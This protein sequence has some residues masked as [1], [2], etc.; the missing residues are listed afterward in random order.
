MKYVVTLH[1]EIYQKQEIKILVDVP[2]DSKDRDELDPNVYAE[3]I[4]LQTLDPDAESSFLEDEF[5]DENGK[6]HRTFKKLEEK[7]II[8]KDWHLVEDDPGR[9]PFVITTRKFKP[10]K[11]KYEK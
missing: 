2:A 10:T 3:D 7:P 1:R 6:V 11:N 9:H 4:V 8:L 5:E